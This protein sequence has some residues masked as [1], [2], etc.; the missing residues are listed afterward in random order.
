MEKRA[1]ECVNRVIPQLSE[2]GL[3]GPNID[4]CIVFVDETDIRIEGES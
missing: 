1:E 4:N 2:V 3:F